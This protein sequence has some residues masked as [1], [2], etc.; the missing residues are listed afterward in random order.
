MQSW[1]GRCVDR[2]DKA[3]CYLN[4]D[5]NLDTDMLE[6]GG[7]AGSAARHAQLAESARATGQWT[8]VSDKKLYAFSLFTKADKVPAGADWLHEIKCEGYRMMVIRD[9]DRERL[10]SRGS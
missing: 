7:S 6:A 2:A 5:V 3:K 10:I 9:L 8:N 4:D 1:G